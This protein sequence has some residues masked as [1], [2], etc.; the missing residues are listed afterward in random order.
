[1]ED[2]AEHDGSFKLLGGRLC[3]DFAN[4]ADWHARVEVVELLV[5]YDRL[6]D[7][8][9]QVGTLTHEQAETLRGVAGDRPTEAAV[10]LDRAIVVREAIYQL[11]SAFAAGQPLPEAALATFNAALTEA[12]GHLQVGADRDG[13]TWTWIGADDALDRPLWSVVRSAADL[14]TSPERALVREC[15][16]PDCGWLFLDTSRNR[17]RRWCDSRSCGNRQRVRRHYQRRRGRERAA[18]TNVM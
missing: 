4:T 17:S 16:G 9:H 1:M 6:L 3:L 2:H 15:A 7:W 13:L 12:L 10:V 5:D 8:G 11:F 18:M 14:L